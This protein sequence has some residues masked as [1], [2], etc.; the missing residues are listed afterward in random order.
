[1]PPVQPSMALWG[2]HSPSPEREIEIVQIEI[3]DRLR[4]VG[5]GAVADLMVSIAETGLIQ[6]IVLR[7][8]ERADGD[9]GLR[10]VAGLHRLEAHRRLGRQTI[11][12]RV[13]D[14]SDLDA[15]QAEIDENLVRHDTTGW[16]RC[17]F[18]AARASIYAERH[19]EAVMRVGEEG[20]RGRGRPRKDQFRIEIRKSGDWYIPS[21][22]GFAAEV[23]DQTGLE[24]DTIARDAQ[25]WAALHPFDA[26]IRALPIAN[27]T[28]ALR[29]LAA[30]PPELRAP[31]IALLADGETQ[32]STALVVADGGKAPA[33]RADTPADE[34]LRAFRKLWGAATPSARGLILADL[35]AR[36][37]PGAWIITE[38]TDG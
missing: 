29:Q 6:P 18:V 23:A 13:I 37:L 31:A 28:R 15:R 8:F 14:L 7:P 5:E 25:I 24:R 22:M 35:A 34:T 21:I 9:I 27:D 36:S 16:S 11:R 17:R 19:P 38:R 2:R 30:A 3:G 1:M 12:A 32:V 10:L 20:P 4:D 26:T 33:Q